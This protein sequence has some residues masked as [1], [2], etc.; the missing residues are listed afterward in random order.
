MVNQGLFNHIIE[1]LISVL[2]ELDN[3]DQKHLQEQQLGA[4]RLTNYD[5]SKES[6]QRGFF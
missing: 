1:R 2:D 4:D 3:K 5:M 6:N